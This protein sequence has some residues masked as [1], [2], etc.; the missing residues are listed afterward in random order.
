MKTEKLF[1]KLDVAFGGLSLLCALASHPDTTDKL[2]RDVWDGWGYTWTQVFM[3]EFGMRLPQ[4]GVTMN[5]LV[6][7]LNTGSDPEQFQTFRDR[8]DRL[9]PGMFL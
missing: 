7:K 9:F 1:E 4:V 3:G 2:M 5:E 6:A 8:I